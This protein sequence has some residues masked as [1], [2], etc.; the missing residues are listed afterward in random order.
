[1]KKIILSSC[2]LLSLCAGLAAAAPPA[3]GPDSVFVGIYVNRIYDVSLR[4]NKFSV[5]FY[6]WFRWK[7]KDL[8]P[9]KSFEI[10]GGEKTFKSEPYR[11]KDKE[12]NYAF[13]RV[14][15]V[16]TQY[17]DVSAFPFDDH[18]LTVQIEDGEN[19]TGTLVYIL[20]A[21]NLGKSPEVRIPGWSLD[22]FYFGVVPYTYATNYGDPSLP[23]ENQSIF[24]R[25]YCSVRVIRPGAGYFIKLLF[26]MFI[27][28]FIAFLAFFIRPTDL[29]PRFG[30]GVGGIFAAVASQYVITSSLPDTNIMTIADQL[31][32]ATFIFVFLSIAESTISLWLFN[33]GREQRSKTV[34]HF[35][36]YAVPISYLVV[37]LMI[38][39]FR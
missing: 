13:S 14:S 5:D 33:S 36:R 15:A 35:C 22:K 4:D 8:D 6:L 38:A 20:D 12:I 30:L 1:M 39:L 31:H 37:C 2:A 28:A 29:D 7:N 11:S 19:E 21:G 34:D 9:I 16:M 17:W 25:F 10:V 32:M 18:A 26:G 24:S 23:V 27:A 3:T